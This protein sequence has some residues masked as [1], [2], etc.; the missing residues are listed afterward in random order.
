[1]STLFI[2]SLSS[3]GKLQDG[4]L[5][6]ANYGLQLI[7]GHLLGLQRLGRWR[8]F[9]G[10]SFTSKINISAWSLTSIFRL[11]MQVPQE[12]KY[13][14]FCEMGE[15]GEVAGEK[16]KIKGY[17]LSHARLGFAFSQK[18]WRENTLRHVAWLWKHAFPKSTAWL[19][20]HLQESRRWA[21]TRCKHQAGAQMWQLALVP[22]T[23]ARAFPCGI[24]LKNPEASQS[25]SRGWD[26][27]M[28]QTLV[29]GSPSPAGLFFQQPGKAIIGKGNEIESGTLCKYCLGYIHNPTPW[30]T[31]PWERQ[32]GPLG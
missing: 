4:S 20:V 26:F 22:L 30:A 31:F 13:L 9:Q 28:M 15:H 24:S 6:E 5:E 1:M 3:Q 14:P 18:V 21:C 25:L 16:R 32:S 11:F 7:N 12:K 19:M 2:Q 29:L 10:C 8:V 17:R 27:A 23:A